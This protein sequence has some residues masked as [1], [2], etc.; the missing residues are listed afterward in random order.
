MRNDM[1]KMTSDEKKVRDF[2]ENYWTI[3][4]QRNDENLI[5]GYHYGYYERGINNWKEAVLNMNDFVGKLIGLDNNKKME[6]LDAGSGPGFVSNYLASKFPNI[7]FKGI[8]L[9]SKEVELATK[10]KKEKHH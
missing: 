2:Y 10:M 5:L 8:T 9:S 7:N 1:K 6:I 4:T 3:R